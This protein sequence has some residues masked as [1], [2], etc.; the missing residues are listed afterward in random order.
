MN[1]EQ[2]KQYFAP[3]VDLPDSVDVEEHLQRAIKVGLDDFW[4]AHDW[5]F[6]TRNDEISTVASQQ[7]YTLD[8]DFDSAISLVEKATLPGNRLMF[9]PREEFEYLVPDGSAHTSST[10][11]VYTVYY[12][13]TARRH[14]MK[15]LRIPQAAI[16]LYLWQRN[17]PPLDASGVPS[18]FVGGLIAYCWKYIW[19]TGPNRRQAIEEAEVELQ[20]CIKRD[21]SYTARKN[22][23]MLDAADDPRQRGFLWEHDTPWRL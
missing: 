10:P 2:L 4:R 9:L 11:S 13:E 14:K 22:F 20:N 12:D 21:K 1:S 6:A 8:E 19:P 5:T 15:L 23:I 7:E 16:T 3:L 18:Q 17:K